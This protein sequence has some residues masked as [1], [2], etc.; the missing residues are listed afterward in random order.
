MLAVILCEEPGEGIEEKAVLSYSPLT[1]TSS[2][3]GPAMVRL[4]ALAFVF[5][6]FA[7]P[8]LAQDQQPLTM[9]RITPEGD[10]VAATRQIVLEFNR[11]VVA[12]G[13]MSRTADEVG[14]TLSPPV[15]CQW[16]WLNTSSLSCNL[17]DK[18]AL[19][20]ATTYTMTITPR[21]AA[22][23]GAVLAEEK[24]HNFT[25]ARPA[26]QDSYLRTWS[27]PGKPVFR[28]RFNQPVTKAS[29]SQSVYFWDEK[30]Q[31]RVPAYLESEELDE[32]TKAVK[33]TTDQDAFEVW[34]AAPQ[35]DLPLNT[36]IALKEGPGLK[37][38]EGE[39]LS[40]QDRVIREFYTFPEFSFRGVLCRDKENTEVLITPGSA[41][42]DAQLCNPM[43]PV[44]LSFT[45]PI[46]RSMVK[47]HVTFAPGLA[48]G[49]TDFN[50][51]GDENRDYS[52]LYDDRSVQDTPYNISLPVYLKAAQDYTLSVGERKLTLWEKIKN[53]FKREKTLPQTNLA[54]EFGRTVAP[55]TIKFATGH[56]NP[57]FEMVYRDAVLEKGVDSEVPLYVNNLEE[58]SF[59]YTKLDANGTSEGDTKTIAIPKVQDVQFAMPVGVRDML[60]GKS[61]AVSAWLS[62]T[63]DVIGKWT[64]AKRLFAQVT[65]Y[66]VYTKLG[67]FNSTIWVTDLA[68]GE[69]VTDA[70]V[71]I[72]KSDITTLR[73]PEEPL[74]QTLTD[75]NG[76]ATL[77][78]LE[79]LDPNL[80]LL[81]SY[82]DEDS[83]LFVRVDKGED[84]ALLPISSDYELSLWEIAT[85]IYPYT[86]EKYGHMKAWGMTAQGIYRAGDTMQ[87]KIYVRDQDN[88]R[89]IT[90]PNGTYKL[91][92]SD[93]AGKIV[94]TR[95]DVKL[96]E[97]GTFSGDY[98]IPTASPVGWFTF[99]LVA[100]LRVDGKDVEKEFYPLSVL[101]SDFTPAPFRVSTEING[102]KFKP[103][104]TISITTDAALHSGGPYGEAAVRNNITL[105]SRAFRSKD[106]VA[107]DYT[108][109]SYEDEQ[110]SED[111]FQ[112][113]DKLNDKGEWKTDFTL[114]EKSIVYGDL[115]IEGSVQDDRGKSVAGFAK[116]A[117]VGVDRMV[118]LRTLS[119]VYESKKPATVKTIVVDE[120][121]KPVADVP[122]TVTVEKEEVVTAKVKGA[123]NAYLNDPTTEWVKTADCAVKSAAEGEDCTFTP[124]SAGS[125]RVIA[126]IEDTKGRKHS[127]MT[128]L[129]VSGEDYVQWNEGKAY[130]LSIIPEEKDYKVGDTARYLVKNP[131]PGANALVTVERYGVIHSFVQKLEG[132][133]PIIELPIKPDYVPGYYMSV[134]LFSPR[135]DA[136]PPEMGQIDMGKP[137]FRAGYV[138][139][140]ITDPYKT[141]S[142]S[143]KTDAEV[144]RPRDVVKVELNVAPLHKS[145]TKEPV[146]LA[147]AVLDESVF[148]LITNGKDAFDPYNG[149]Y[150]LESLDVANYSLMTRLLG[151][152][153]F[154]KKGA[155]PGGDGGVDA[156]MR[157]LFKFVSYWNPSVPIDENGKAKIEFEA[158]DN[159]TGW[160]ILALAT[161]PNDLMG[162]GEA[163]FKVNRPTEIRPAMPNQIREGDKF[164]A[165]FSVMNRTDKARTIKVT[166]TANGNLAGKETA[167]HEQTVELEPYKRT[168]ILMPLEAALLPISRGL[169]EGKIA[170]SVT[171]GDETDSDGL[172]H[173]LPIL[174]SRT[175]QTAASY[176]TSTKDSVSENIAVPKDIFYD[177]GEI[178][179]TLS[180]SVIAGLDGAF[181]YMRDYPYICWEQKLTTAV[182]ASHYNNL[183]PYLDEKTLWENAGELPQRTIDLASSYQAPNG[184][185]TYFN[186][187]DEF[188]DPYL[189]AYTAL[190]FGWM[191]QAGY[192]VPVNVKDNLEKYLLSFLRNNS[193]PSYYS[194]SMTDTVR[195]VILAA[196]KDSGKITKNDILRLRPDAKNIGL[197]GK[198]HYL[199]AASKLPETKAAAKETLNSIFASGVESGGK[200]SFNE[201]YDGEY[202][203]ILATPLRDNCAILDAMLQYGDKDLIGDKPFKL[204]RMIT[205]GR[206]NRDHF[207]NTQENMFCMNALL[208][209]ARQ[210]ESEEPD[211]TLTATYADKPLGETVFEDVK[212]K[213]VTLE[214]PLEESD[215]GKTSKL[216]VNRDGDGRYYYAARLTYAPKDLKDA[217]NAGIDIRREY[218]IQDGKTWKKSSSPLT[219][220]R[221]DVV[222]VDINLSVPTARSFVAIHDPLPGALETVNRD[223]ATA[224]AV[225]DADKDDYDPDYRW[226]FYHREL[227]H[228]SARFYADWI[229]PGN[230][231]L[232][233]TAQAIATGTFSAPPVKAEE[234]YDPDVYG[235]GIKD[236]VL[237][238]EKP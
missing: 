200:F 227:R 197:F 196:Y 125:Y 166:I 158:P 218:F 102:E 69:V 193:A 37:S 45:A 140:E 187:K 83:R 165:G 233:Y 179:V 194:K 70:K 199:L 84:M 52:R 68:T 180:P 108:F 88:N 25:T 139:T 56:R 211:M 164:S 219:I 82:E 87:Y 72:Y 131:W 152:Q 43:Q 107:K 105:V 26:L 232:S 78:G 66:Q 94:E 27:S 205:Q 60:D 224:S 117:Y 123:G 192:K 46:M 183:K 213:P 176:G 198:A 181:L 201:K 63:P 168:N 30:T 221:G 121:G 122:V 118:G 156:G 160:R 173:T 49:L 109:D 91:E 207:E 81:R 132:S 144:Y 85:D 203:R 124:Q 229:E 92:I 48:G 99:K 222:K 172:E 129:W 155:N 146:E 58:F 148:D 101:V 114:P 212:N 145:E 73:Q 149:F 223:L 74:A 33:Q 116:A 210:Y 3:K 234:M 5:I 65:P 106:P 182:M 2:L 62:T 190:A 54:D 120:A 143:A 67:H 225:D 14:I 71:S 185:M 29:A 115:N 238:T 93:P 86:R 22:E 112:K 231:K 42:T 96:T 216:I 150:D 236:E 64:G 128:Y 126:N 162:L 51:W 138:Q 188:V 206:G 44:S 191:E 215:I 153:K 186:G 17:D 47:D 208:N 157:N 41:Q 161:T 127:S 159:L 135:V 134:T 19:K 1:Q 184:G 119:W 59:G 61:G 24:I 104:D 39:A 79:T 202:E 23:D 195:S 9:L 34:M 38:N 90:P 167:L 204:V 89:F 36:K 189:S 151:R 40:I 237:V 214:K 136:P 6:S 133:T 7:L 163:N 230:Y 55:F 228:D 31:V 103:G 98:K 21:I 50:P 169:P 57:N 130:A 32:A 16:Q 100:K 4:A 147:V 220:K 75:K 35:T 177:S 10:D 77:P 142:V 53:F 95:E 170:F 235:L 20:L 113:E 171:A 175:T 178:G 15:N 76:I 13:N 12:V 174:K 141:M 111:I 154:E 110:N 209:Y 80:E 11:P 137:A 28:V 18:E 226:G 217:V 97:F 8:V